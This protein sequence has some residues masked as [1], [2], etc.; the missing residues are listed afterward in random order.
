MKQIPIFVK[1]HAL[2]GQHVNPYAARIDCLPS[3]AVASTG[4]RY[5][6]VARLRFQ[7]Q[8]TELIFPLLGIAGNVPDFAHLCL[9]Q[10]ADATCESWEKMFH[11]RPNPVGVSKQA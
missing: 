1:L 7:E 5:A 3:H 9:V 11:A 8:L 4:D 10:S 2:E 6:Q